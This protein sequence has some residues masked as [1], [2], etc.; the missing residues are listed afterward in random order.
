M[1]VLSVSLLYFNYILIAYQLFDYYK[2]MW[3]LFPHGN[4]FLSFFLEKVR[5]WRFKISKRYKK[6][7]KM[8][9]NR[10]KKIKETSDV[11]RGLNVKSSILQLNK[12]KSAIINGTGVTLNLSSNIT[13]DSDDEND[14]RHK[15]L[16]TNTQV[17]RFRK[18]FSNASCANIKLSKTQLHR[19]ILAK[20]FRTI[21]KNSI[22]FNR[23]CIEAIS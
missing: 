12:L 10:V 9:K 22:T 2:A 1:S 6:C 23:K 16:L 14:F 5:Q 13:D 8:L 18:A 11:T 21:I 3:P 7:S 4:N 19:R 17:S 15:L 20:I